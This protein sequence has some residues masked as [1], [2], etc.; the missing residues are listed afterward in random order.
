MAN[1]IV[2]EERELIA[3]SKLSTAY[4]K[5]KIEFTIEQEILFET[6]LRGRKERVLNDKRELG[7]ALYCCLVCNDKDLEKELKWWT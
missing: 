5:G 6:I 7:E 2:E 3:Y 1:E 4:R